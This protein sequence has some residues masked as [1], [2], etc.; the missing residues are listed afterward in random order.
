GENE[1]LDTLNWLRYVRRVSSLHT[2]RAPRRVH[3]NRSSPETVCRGSRYPIANMAKGN[4]SKEVKAFVA[5]I[6]S[7]EIPANTEQALKSRK[8][9]KAM[10][11]EMEALTKNNTWKNCVLPHGKKTVG[12][13]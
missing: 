3:P 1:C 8:W 2:T 12:C 11:E 6:Y 10:E 9:K 7:D 4:L 13:W 5:S